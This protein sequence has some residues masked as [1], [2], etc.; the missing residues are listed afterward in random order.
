MLRQ[1]LKPTENRVVL[2]LPTEYIG[3]QIEILAFPLDEAATHPSEPNQ[4][5]DLLSF[6]GTLRDSPNFNSDLVE[7]QRGQRDEWR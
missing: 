3:H 7:W 2:E 6:A 4:S 5:F 1:I